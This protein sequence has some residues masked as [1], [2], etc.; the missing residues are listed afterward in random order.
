MPDTIFYALVILYFA[1][2]FLIVYKFINLMEELLTGRVVLRSRQSRANHV[3][4]SS[5]TG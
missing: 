4:T 1:S 3:V 2:M 5:E